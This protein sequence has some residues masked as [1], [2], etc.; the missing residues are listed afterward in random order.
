MSDW[1]SVSLSFDP[2]SGLKPPIQSALQ[3][4]EVTEAILEALLD[5]VKV[6][7]LDVTNPAYA[8]VS[9]LIASVRTI[10]EQLK[11]SGFS[12]LLVHPDFSRQDMSAVFQSVS[13]P[14]SVFESKVVSKF[15]D[16]S[17]VFR[18]TY[19]A[20]SA[21]A[22]LVFYTSAETPGD[23][24]AQLTALLNFIKHPKLLPGLPAP[25]DLKVRPALKSD[26]PTAIA[27]NVVKSFSRLWGGSYEKA[28]V[29]EWRMPSAPVASSTPNFINQFSTFLNSY[30]QPSFI[31]ERSASPTGE[32][33]VVELRTQTT[34]KAVDA[35]MDKYSFPL[36][37]N[38]VELREESGNVY[39]NFADA[40]FDVS[41][42]RL[43]EGFATGTYRFVDD[44]PMLVAGQT[45]Y[46]RIRAYFGKPSAW[47]KAGLFVSDLGGGR[48]YDQNALQ[49]AADSMGKD[50]AL[51]KTTGNQKVLN[52]GQGV[53][54]GQ[55]SAVVRGF[56]PKS[57]SDLGDF[58]P[59]EAV[60]QAIQAGI[61]LNFE[62]PPA[63]PDDLP[64]RASQKTGWGSLSAVG[65]QIGLLKTQASSSQELV[66]NV[67][68]K[69]ACRRVANSVLSSVQTSP[70]LV[71]LLLQKWRQGGVQETVVQVLGPDDG[72]S[73]ILTVRVPEVNWPFIGISGTGSPSDQM[74]IDEYLSKEDDYKDGDPL[75]G[76]Y[77]L[78]PYK[79]KGESHFVDEES[80]AGLSDF[81]AMCLSSGQSA[82][83]LSWYTVT[84][85]DLFPSFIPFIFDFDQFLKSLLKAVDSTVKEIES[86][87]QQVLQKIRQLEAIIQAIDDLLDLLNITVRLSILGVSSTSGSA[88]S[89]ASAMIASTAKPQGPPFGLHSGLVMTFGGPGLGSIAA[90]N[91]ITFILGFNAG[92][93]EP[94]SLVA[95]PTP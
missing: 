24:M 85:S 48:T 4:L 27:R 56:V 30:R 57:L 46:Y 75:T 43:G 63:S 41:G 76:P 95:V 6:F 82:S 73:D 55:P 5:L 37:S 45:Y 65:G 47:M 93:T 33:V 64:F 90:F 67:F 26:D 84:L 3:V 7:I 66:R 53:T 2:V 28:L 86:V 8:I 14:Y 36:P 23:L 40:R 32:A 88:E 35:L 18:P 20:G 19:P 16:T 9:L 52:Y 51:V 13:G 54:M 10:I 89:L 22:M 80:R 49:S 60:Y 12:V 91:A 29:L 83:Y 72:T 21:V 74:K 69:T 78:R 68:F 1:A 81:L 44:D 59:Y 17:D 25:T 11:A 87:I 71:D 61:L 50:K 31:V 79:I 62:F 42:V 94:E 34:G 70:R 58:N 77:P 15:H 92:S 39:R 38:R